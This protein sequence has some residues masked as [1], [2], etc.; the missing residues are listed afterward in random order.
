[1]IRYYNATIL[2]H[3]PLKFS[4]FEYQGIFAPFFKQK[5]CIK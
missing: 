2:Y 1:M 4:S 5:E 3:I